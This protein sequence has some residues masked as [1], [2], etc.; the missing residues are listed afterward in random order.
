[1][2]SLSHCVRVPF[3]GS[4]P[5]LLIS[6]PAVGAA[7]ILIWSYSCVFLPPMSTAISTSMFSFVRALND[8]LYVSIGTESA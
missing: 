5:K 8:L 4:P 6:G 3:L 2:F 7:E 1:M